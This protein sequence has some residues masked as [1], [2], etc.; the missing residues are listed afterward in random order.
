MPP[1]FTGSAKHPAR[2]APPAPLRYPADGSAAELVRWQREGWYRPGT[3]LDDFDA[4]AAQ[5]PGAEL[6]FASRHRPGPGR[7]TLAELQRR[8]HRVAAGLRRLGVRPGGVVALQLPNWPEAVVALYA[9]LELGAVALPII[10]SYDVA[11]LTFILG[12]SGARVF[13]V[14]DA[15][16]GV[17]CAARALEVRQRTAVRDVVVVG[18]RV[19]QAAVAWADLDA[20][21]PQDRPFRAAVKGT[22]PCLLIYTSGTTAEPKGVVHTHNTLRAELTS[23]P[24]RA[25][26]DAAL[27]ACWPAG[28]IAGLL[29]HLR[30]S[31]GA[32]L[33]VLMDTWD[34]DLAAELVQQHAITEAAGTPFFLD[35]LLRAAERAGQD[36]ASLG[37]FR[38]SAASVPPQLVK[39]STDAGI[40]TFRAYGSSEHPTISCGHRDATLDKRLNTDGR[41]I[42]GIDIRL[43]DGQGRDVPEGTPGEILSRGPDLFVGY[44][45]PALNQRAF[46]NGWFAT[47]DVGHLDA[48]GY[49]TIS[50]RLKDIVIRGGENISSKE[51]EDVLGRHSAVVE[52]AVVGAADAVYGERVCAFVIVNSES[53]LDLAEVCRHFAAERVARHKTPERLVIVDELPRTAAGKIKKFELRTQ[54]SQELPERS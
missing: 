7:L 21:G 25:G 24:Y 16:R 44:L 29:S 48:D 40:V 6:V 15:W 39:R 19:P 52:C 28:H 3:L 4:G 47:G 17:D 37:E 9:T 10:H 2:P 11:E 51:V 49:L 53:G 35:G 43:V 20:P 50:D 12:Q 8:S 45:D 54:A 33:L 38:V 22:D 26:P 18:E 32:R 1:A 30:L 41:M 5:R 34:A 23:E 46:R 13:V 27:L 36:L 31:F 14:P 42:A